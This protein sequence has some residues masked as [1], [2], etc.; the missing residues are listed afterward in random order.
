MQC[1]IS[2]ELPRDF[3]KN[4]EN[5][6]LDTLRCRG[7]LPGFDD[8]RQNL[9]QRLPQFSVAVEHVF[10][11]ARH[12]FGA[13]ISQHGLRTCLMVFSAYVNSVSPSSFLELLSIGLTPS[14][15]DTSVGNLSVDRLIEGLID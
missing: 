10:P 11:S 8:D 6:A 5:S 13:F 3:R 1:A 14:D 15:S 7:D 9:E 2:V 4:V 12:H